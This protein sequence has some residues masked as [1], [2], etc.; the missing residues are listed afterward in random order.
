MWRSLVAH[1]FWEQG[2]AGSNPAIR[3][4]FRN[5]SEIYLFI[6]LGIFLIPYLIWRLFKTD[7]FAPLPVIQIVSGVLF[8]P[9]IFGYFFPNAY[10]T[11]FTADTTKMLSG[12]ATLAVVLFVFTAGVEVDINQAW[13]DK[14]DT[15]TTSFFALITPLICG[16]IVAIFISLDDKWIGENSHEWQFVLSVGMA[17]AVTALPILILLLDKMNIL[18]SDIGIR[19]LRYSSFDDIAIWTVF[20]LILL[21][22]NRIVRQSLFFLLY[23][24][25][26]YL[27]IKFSNK[28]KEQDRLYFALIWLIA[29][30]YFSDWAGLHYL[31]GGFLAGFIIK[32]EWIGHD[33]LINLRKYVLLLIMPIF[34]LN[35]GLRTNWELT[36]TSVIYIAVILFA[37]Q[38]F[39]K[40]LGI[41]ISGRILKWDNKEAVTIGWLLQTK[42]LIEIIF[43]TIM[44]DKGIIS[45]PMFTALLFMAIMSTVVTMP[46]VS[47]RLKNQNIKYI[48]C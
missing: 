14:K 39:G 6:V 2:V 48:K 9:G 44:L 11:L 28:V 30:A 40:I 8:G 29:C 12:V 13:I 3:T 17:M 22:W 35:T 45:A 16:A 26:S 7:N 37:T 15:L 1:L 25:A 18:K 33:I 10:S 24:I 47:R 41:S 42:A 5:P 20:A 23:I 27:I 43:C 19:C 34:F 21:D 38:A 32:E 31:V 4:V 36:D 46:V